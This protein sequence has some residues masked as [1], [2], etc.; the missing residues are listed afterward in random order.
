VRDDA[1]PAVTPDTPGMEVIVEI[2][3]KR[4]GA[5]V[6]LDAEGRI[7]GIVT[8]G[9]IRRL[10]EKGQ[11]IRS[12]NA[13]D[14]M[15]KNPRTIDADELAVEGFHLMET[16]KITQLIVTRNG[17]YAGIVHLHDILREGIF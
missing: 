9:D 4:L 7:V 11:D 5:A 13:A 8:D 15:G 12:V 17:E 6:V 10:V 14:M 2:S 3:N 1:R 16:H